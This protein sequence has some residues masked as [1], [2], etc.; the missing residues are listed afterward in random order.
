[1][2]KCLGCGIELQSTNASAAG[3]TPKEDVQYCQ[4]CF[5]LRH[6]GDFNSALLPSDD[7]QEIFASITKI[8]ALFFWVVDLFD[9]ESSFVENINRHL[10]GKD[11]IMI[12]TKRDLLPPTLSQN[13][14]N[15]FVKSRLRE[16]DVSVLGYVVTGD[17]GQDGREEIIAAIETYRDGRDVVFFGMANA[18][19]STLLNSVFENQT[20]TTSPYPGTTL[21]TNYF[22]WEDFRIYDTPGYNNKYSVLW[23]VDL[24]QLKII[25]PEKLVAPRIFQIHED[26]SYA[27]GG[28]ARLD[29]KT[30]EEVSAVFYFASDLPLH[31]GKLE[32]ADVLWQKHMGTLLQ[33]T[34]QDKTMKKRD[35]A[36]KSEN[37]DIVIPG[38]GWVSLKGSFQEIM[39]W[40][41]PDL[42]VTTREAMI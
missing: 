1:M 22:T 14:L 17:Y 12:L 27:I 6:Y 20:I 15:R 32:S 29:I 36:Q 42:F 40:I 7:N 24:G 38:L 37:I 5:R 2:A 30:K 35:I 16:Y 10:K 19:K 34:L 33:P 8:D 11:I 26:Q 23:N 13:K 4:R 18:G 31:R 25:L 9:F 39:L 41:H 21:A 3:Y 28:I